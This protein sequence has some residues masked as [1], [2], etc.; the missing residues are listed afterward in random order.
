MDEST[1]LK[2]RWS[3]FIVKIKERV[4][5]R[6]GLHSQA[7]GRWSTTNPPLATLPDDLRDLVLPDIGTLWFGWDY[8]AQEPRLLM[9]YSKSKVLQRAFGEGR[10]IHTEFVCQMYGWDAPPPDF[11]KEDARRV[12][13]KQARYE[14][15]YL[16]TGDNA[17]VQ[18]VKMGADKTTLRQ[19]LTLLKGS[20][21]EIARYQMRM[22]GDIGRT[23]VARTWAGRRRVYVAGVDGKRASEEMVRK[24]YNFRNQGGG[25]DILN[26]TVV[27][28]AEKIPHAKLAY[29]MHDSLWLEISERDWSDELGRQIKA[30]AE[31]PRNIDGMAV[32]FPAT[33]KIMNDRGEVSKWKG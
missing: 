17:M 22:R 2:D 30:I 16:G 11:R 23:R 3:E 18:A 31:Q 19:A 9:G 29:S 4:Y 32:C 21:P 5:P 10:D 25:A 28:L 7:T 24:L 20:D 6:F 1:S 14:I 27:E 8:D 15:W 13:A 26:L 33:Y 12:F